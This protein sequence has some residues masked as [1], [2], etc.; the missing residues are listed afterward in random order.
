[1]PCENEMRL[2]INNEPNVISSSFEEDYGF[3]D[4]NLESIDRDQRMQGGKADDPVIDSDMRDWN[5][6]GVGDSTKR[7]VILEV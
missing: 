6:Q 7:E 5:R 3:I 1:M 4:M 2:R